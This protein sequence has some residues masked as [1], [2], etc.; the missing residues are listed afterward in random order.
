M[1]KDYLSQKENS[2]KKDN[3]NEKQ[4]NVKKYWIH[5][6]CNCFNLLQLNACLLLN[7]ER[8]HFSRQMKQNLMDSFLI[9]WSARQRDSHTD[10]HLLSLISLYL[11][12]VSPK[13]LKKLK[14][15][16]RHIS[17]TFLLIGD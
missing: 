7:I 14:G 8:K 16:W 13:F 15:I 4:F 11:C 17:Q 9:K 1:E 2:P 10:R 12:L 5:F 3:P 6:L